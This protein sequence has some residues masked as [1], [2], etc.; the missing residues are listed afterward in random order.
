LLSNLGASEPHKGILFQW[1]IGSA[2]LHFTGSGLQ[3]SL[4]FKDATPLSW[5]DQAHSSSCFSV[6]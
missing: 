2:L 1:L 4:G 6:G 5:F 3:L